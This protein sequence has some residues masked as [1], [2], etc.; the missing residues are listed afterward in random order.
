MSEEKKVLIID[1]EKNIRMTLEK[2]LSNAD[3]SVQTAYNGEEALE[4]L[5]KEEISVILLDMKLPGM[6]GT[7]VLSKINELDYETKVIIIT[8]YSSVDS[9]VET[10][11]QGAV[12]YLRKPF[13]PEEIVNLV[14]E[15]FKRFQ[16]EKEEN[17][18]DNFEDYISLAKSAINNKKFDQAVEYLNKATSLNAEKPEPFNLLGII[19]ELRNDQP[20]A[21]K[22]YRTALSLDPSY[23]PADDNL[24]RASG[25]SNG[26]KGNL[27]NVNLGE[28]EG[29]GK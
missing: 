5:Q 26:N 12:D 7:E 17:E 23:K 16:L 11:K 24:Q 14:K 19:H 2:A 4:I 20:K 13:K 22:L 25:I 10:M 29:E 3:Y 18:I 21:M 27:K 6:D 1:D 8:G 9:A 15:V 28:E